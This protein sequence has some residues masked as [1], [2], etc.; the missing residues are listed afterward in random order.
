MNVSFINEKKFLF[1]NKMHGLKDKIGEFKDEF[2]EKKS[3]LIQR[4]IR[5]MWKKKIEKIDYNSNLQI[6]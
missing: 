2:K 1:Q 6:K 3:E 5:F 4:Y